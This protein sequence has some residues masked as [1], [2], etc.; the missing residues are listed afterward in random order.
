LEENKASKVGEE[1]YR[2]P[3]PKPRTRE[4]AIVMLADAVEATSRTV[5]EPSYER[6]RSVVDKVIN[7]KF[8]DGQLNDCDITLVNLHRIAE[9]FAHTLTGIYHTRVEYPKKE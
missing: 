7:D 8:I 4:A 1:K 6:L 9:S 2:Y 5:E 3:G